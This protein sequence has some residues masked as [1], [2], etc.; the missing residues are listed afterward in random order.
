M[1]FNTFVNDAVA[2]KAAPSIKNNLSL[3]DSSDQEL[4]NFIQVKLKT[5]P[6][7]CFCGSYYMDY[8]IESGRKYAHIHE[9]LPIDD[10]FLRYFDSFHYSVWYEGIDYRASTLGITLFNYAS[11]DNKREALQGLCMV[12]RFGD[13]FK[14]YLVEGIP[15]IDN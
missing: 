10:D 2:K 1:K 12:G 15:L 8:L 4:L 9:N 7:I 3:K 13:H 5:R 14:I 11:Y 6:A